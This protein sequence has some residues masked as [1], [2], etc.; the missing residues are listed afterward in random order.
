MMSAEF[1]GGLLRTY[2]WKDLLAPANIPLWLLVIAGVW[3]AFV[4]LR[5]LKAITAQTREL[6]R[7]NETIVSKERARLRVEMLPFDPLVTKGNLH[8]FEIRAEVS[9]SGPTDA[10]IDHTEFRAVIGDEPDRV[11]FNA[12]FPS[13]MLNVG[14]VIKAGARPVQGMTLLRLPSA[15]I[16]GPENMSE[17]VLGKRGIHAAGS[18]TYRDVFDG[19]WI[20]RFRY[21]YKANYLNDGTPL[22]GYWTQIG[23]PEQNGEFRLE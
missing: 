23:T 1:V 20:F 4:A 19:R 6:R 3:V 2:P 5:N 8:A 13:S 12:S 22:G 18:I 7:Q 15:E 11:D 10:F 21:F 16:L 9:I 17:I 14:K